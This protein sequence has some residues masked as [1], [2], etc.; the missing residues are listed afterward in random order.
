MAEPDSITGTIQLRVR[1]VPIEMT[2]T[3]P[4]TKVPPSAMLPVFRRIT[5]SIIDAMVGQA[6]A[7]GEKV[8]CQAGCGACCRQYIPIAHVEA[9]QLAELVSALPEPRQTEIRRRFAEAAHRFG[10]LDHSA[11]LHDVGLAFIRAGIPCP[12]LENETCSIYSERPLSCREHLVTSAPAHCSDPTPETV[13][14]VPMPASVSNALIA[15]NP[16]SGSLARSFVPLVL[17]LEWAEKHPDHTA[18]ATGPEF[19]KRIIENLS[20]KPLAD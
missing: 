14:R 13:T 15:L 4:S 6:E 17:A 3:V 8:S 12:F 18:N 1:G 20:G 2:L 19:L 16:E 11:S 9:R 10:E 5:H 7:G